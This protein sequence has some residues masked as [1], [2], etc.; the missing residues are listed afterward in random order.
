[1][2]SQILYSTN[3]WFAVEVSARY[4]GNVFFAW[5]SEYFNARAAPSDSAAALIAPSS[6]PCRIYRDL[7]EDWKHQ[8][9]HSALIKGYTRKFSRLAKDWLAEG[10]ITK[11]HYDE[12]IASVRG[13]T[14]SI[15]RPV[16]YVVPRE[17]IE[18]AG[19]L[20]PVPRQAR[21]AY[22]PELQVRDLRRDEFDIIELEVV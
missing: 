12:I 13:R 22:G 9:D 5:V 4:R 15:W 21:A 7:L 6:S 20:F 17:P 10:S 1:M 14:W 2:T 8:D 19:R 18:R 11:D 16:L 3:P